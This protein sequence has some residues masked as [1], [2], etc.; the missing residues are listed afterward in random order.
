MATFTK[1]LYYAYTDKTLRIPV[2]EFETQLFPT[3][4]LFVF[5]VRVGN[6]KTDQA[7]RVSHIFNV[8][9]QLFGQR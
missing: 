6:R 4:F 1:S 8:F 7:N 3:G 2:T 5:L 9:Q